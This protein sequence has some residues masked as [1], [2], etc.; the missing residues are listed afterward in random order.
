MQSRQATAAVEFGLALPILMLL[1]MGG[2]EMTRYILIMQKLS[3]T[4]STMA[5]LVSR[6]QTISNTDLTNMYYA[7]SHLME[8]YTFSSN[9]VVII[10]DISNNGTKNIVNWQVSGGGTFSATSKVGTSGGTATLPANF[11]LSVNEDT[12]SSEIFYNYSPLIAPNI[13][14]AKVIYEI[15]FYKPRLGTLTTLGS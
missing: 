13:V 4:V 11:N 6:S 12:I 14:A 3:K 10:S 1:A 2:F 8:P 7:V 5:D 15:K 9:G